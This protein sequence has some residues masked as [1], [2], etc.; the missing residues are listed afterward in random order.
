M[1]PNTTF[2]PYHHFQP[3]TDYKL[4]THTMPP[5]TRAQQQDEQEQGSTLALPNKTGIKKASK[6]ATKSKTATK[7]KS[8]QL[9]DEEEKS[10]VMKT[11]AKPKSKQG[12]GTD[13]EEK[14][15]SSTKSKKAR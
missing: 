4:R 5:R 12:K 9:R 8:K 11:T 6:I 7:S 13:E 1:H 10:G 2:R 14:K 3:T 15:T